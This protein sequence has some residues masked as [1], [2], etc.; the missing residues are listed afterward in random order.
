MVPEEVVPLNSTVLRVIQSMSRDREG[1][2][3]PNGEQYLTM[4]PAVVLVTV[5]NNLL[6]F[7][8]ISSS[9]SQTL[10]QTCILCCHQIWSTTVY[11]M[12]TQGTDVQV[13]SI[14]IKHTNKGNLTF[15]RYLRIPLLT[16]SLARDLHL[17][18]PPPQISNPR[19]LHRLRAVHCQTY[20]ANN[21][22]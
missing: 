11:P 12:M 9:V 22:L 6:P 8:A 5:R 2:Q 4:V 13:L 17:S 10:K 3:T 18:T 16:T 14:A 21:R 1:L 7:C 15:R 20:L 19:F